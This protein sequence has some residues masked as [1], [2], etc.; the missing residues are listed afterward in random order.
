MRKFFKKFLAAS[1]VMTMACGCFA[2][3]GSEEKKEETI[4]LTVYSELANV[5]GE[6]V[7]W[8]AKIPKDKF[9]VISIKT[10]TRTIKSK[11]MIPMSIPIASKKLLICMLPI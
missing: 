3:C 10:S 9:N 7:G 8:S 6:Q 11:T 1:M 2:G 5:A 4:T